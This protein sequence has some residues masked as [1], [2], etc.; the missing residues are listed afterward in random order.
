[1]LKSLLNSSASEV[2][3]TR[4]NNSNQNFQT[5]IS[6]TTKSPKVD[7][8]K[9]LKG[10]EDENMSLLCNMINRPSPFDEKEMDHVK[11]PPVAVPPPLQPLLSTQLSSQPKLSATI[12]SE[13]TKG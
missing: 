9:K 7:V 1:M 2:L 5:R 12:P 6:F 8:I 4:T 11:Q 10:C 13:G 3:V